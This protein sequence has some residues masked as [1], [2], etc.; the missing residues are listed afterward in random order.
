MSQPCVVRTESLR[1]FL[2]WKIE[3]VCLDHKIL[4]RGVSLIVLIRGDF[5][6]P[7]CSHGKL[8]FLCL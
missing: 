6:V 5:E 4:F 3:F 7:R 8:N 2:P 1:P